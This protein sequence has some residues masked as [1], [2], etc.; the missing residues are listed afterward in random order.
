MCDLHDDGDNADGHD[1]PRLVG[2]F[3]ESMTDGALDVSRLSSKHK[4]LKYRGEHR[5][6]VL[7]KRRGMQ[8]F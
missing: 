3:D 6:D 2:S 4:L 1:C 5:L 7:R 8:L